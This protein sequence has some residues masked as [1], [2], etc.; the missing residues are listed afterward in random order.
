MKIIIK[1]K[2]KSRFVGC[3]NRSLT[4]G[5]LLGN[6]SVKY[7]G[8]ICQRV[9]NTIN[10]AGYW[11][12]MDSSMVKMKCHSEQYFCYSLDHIP[13]FCSVMHLHVGHFYKKKHHLLVSAGL[14]VPLEFISR[15]LQSL[16]QSCNWKEFVSWM[17]GKVEIRCEL[18][19]W[20]NTPR[21]HMCCWNLSYPYL[22]WISL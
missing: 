15:V 5:C 16:L 22:I 3:E 20:E 10:M 21:F 4:S 6:Q 19:F 9:I 18:C 14:P 13:S 2:F 1:H 12:V 17:E 8:G 11:A 7:N